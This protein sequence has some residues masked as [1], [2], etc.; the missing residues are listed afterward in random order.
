MAKRRL[1]RR[2]QWRI[3]KIQQER[4]Q[5]A[6]KREGHI[7]ESLAH[8]EL[9]PEQHALVIA[10]YGSQVEVEAADGTLHRCQ[11]RTNIGRIVT[12]DQ[13]VWRPAVN[14]SG[15]IVAVSPRT[16]ELSRPDAHGNLRPV[17]ANIDQIFL[18]IAAEPRTPYGLIDRYL[19]A[20][21]NVHI[22]PIILI[23]KADLLSGDAAAWAEEVERIYTA[24]GY[25]L[26]H[27]STRSESDLSCLKKAMHDQ[28]SI[29]VGQSGVGKTSLVNTLLPEVDARVGALSETTR[30]GM[31]TTTTAQLFHLP[32]GGNIID[33]PGIREFGLTHVTPQ[34]LTEGFIEFT[35]LLGHCKF[36]DCKHLHEPGCALQEAVEAGKVSLQ[37]FQSYHQIRESIE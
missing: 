16:S 2:Q 3:D 14:Q 9:G 33:S 19:V 13:V 31:H 30:K 12:G 37:R 18:V 29:F 27:T 7:E 5:R 8:G 36:R 4:K 23:N 34:Q 1:T 24:V 15:V 20:A 11:F 22:R 28:T 6:E 26:I 21:E 35:P 32:E 17:A 25:Q 10:H